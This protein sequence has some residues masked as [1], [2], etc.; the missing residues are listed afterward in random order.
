MTLLKKSVFSLFLVLIL[1][2][3]A[4]CGNEDE[5]AGA[6]NN[7][8]GAQDEEQTGSG[9]DSK[10]DSEKEN[11]SGDGGSQE[12]ESSQQAEMPEPDL[13]NVPDVVATVNGE[14]ISGEEFKSSYEG[15]FQQAAMQSQMTGEEVDQDQLKQQVA[16]SL[17]G[18][19]LLT[20]E[21]ENR[22]LEASQEK[23]DSTLKDLVEQNNFNSQDELMTALKEQQGMNKEEVMA[24]I[25]TQVK[26]DQ[27]ISE[28][29]GDVEPTEEELK[30]A[31][32]QAKAQQAQMS[33]EGEDAETPSFEE[34]KPDLKEQVKSQKEAEA[35][36]ALVEELRKNADVSINL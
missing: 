20:Q 31:Y 19:E 35:S 15:Q 22:N 34:M 27:L 11:G 25:E 12:G 5:S 24:Q 6:N 23:I 10:S 30:Q 4:A 21:A 16:D 17:V 9:S 3:T 18:T 36:Q 7:E 32:E 14:E 1:S 8:S 13:E 2:V 28:E 33:G 29:T 26:I